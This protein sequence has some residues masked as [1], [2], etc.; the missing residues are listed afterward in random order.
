MAAERFL[1]SNDWHG[2]EEMFEDGK[3]LVIFNT[4]QDLNEKIEFYLANQ[5]LANKIA[6]SGYN[7]VQ[8]YTRLNW[9]KEI[10]RLYGQIN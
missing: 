1:I 2:R 10:V 7:K 3:D 4:I 9:A 5:E 8:K 6:K